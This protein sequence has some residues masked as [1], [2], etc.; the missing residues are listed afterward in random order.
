MTLVG[1]MA[2]QLTPL[3]DN[4]AFHAVSLSVKY[5][6]RKSGRQFYFRIGPLELEN[7][8][9]LAYY[10][11]CNGNSLPTFRDKLSVP[12][13]RAKNVLGFLILEYG[14]DKFVP[15]RR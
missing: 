5:K 9:L 1:Y 2:L 4:L 3:T 11:A 6:A 12:S 15:E 7:C 14:T 8:T 10:A 13:S